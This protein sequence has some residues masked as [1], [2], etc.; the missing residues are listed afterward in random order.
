[1]NIS[2]DKAAEPIS[3]LGISKRIGERLTSAVGG[4][5]GL[6][7]SVRFG[8]VL[9][10]RGSMLPTFAA[11]IAAGG[12]VTVTHRD[13]TRYFM[14]VTE[15]CQLVLQASAIGRP[16]EALVLDMG[17]PVKIADIARLLIARSGKDGINIVYTGLRPGEKMHEDLFSADEPR[18]FRPVNPLIS[19]VVV[20]PLTLELTPSQLES[21]ATPTWVRKIMNALADKSA[22]VHTNRRSSVIPSQ[23]RVDRF[24]PF[25]AR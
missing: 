23:S 13:V 6:Y 17:V 24:P 7:V 21:I 19:H 2:T 12:P 22:V 20:P 8:N 18:N 10:S 25:I 1:V 15:A 11:Q 14:T 3:V 4:S 16:G 9:G 5:K